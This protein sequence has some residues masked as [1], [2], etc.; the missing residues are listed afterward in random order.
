M[1]GGK[2]RTHE[3]LEVLTVGNK[4]DKKFGSKS[5]WLVMVAMSKVGKQMVVSLSDFGL[6]KSTR[7]RQQIVLVKGWYLTA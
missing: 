6:R 2:K 7:V 5:G 4:M 1:S 3:E